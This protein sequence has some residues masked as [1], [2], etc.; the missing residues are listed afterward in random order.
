MEHL[1]LCS[2][3]VPEQKFTYQGLGAIFKATFSFHRYVAPRPGEINSLHPSVTH[4]HTSSNWSGTTHYSKTFVSSLLFEKQ[5]WDS[6][7]EYGSNTIEQPTSNYWLNIRN[8][9]I[10]VWLSSLGFLIDT[11]NVFLTLKLT[12]WRGRGSW[13]I[14]HG[15]MQQRCEFLYFGPKRVTLKHSDI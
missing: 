7:D 11:N 9:E 14:Q 13:L 4:S 10:D 2:G 5:F 15:D 12:F 6:F 3:V 8:R 1:F